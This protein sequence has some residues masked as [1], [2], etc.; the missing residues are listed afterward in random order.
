MIVTIWLIRLSSGQEQKGSLCTRRGRCRGWFAAQENRLKLSR[1]TEASQACPKMGI[2][3][4]R[5]GCIV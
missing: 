5:W 3:T 2:R 4:V 1:F